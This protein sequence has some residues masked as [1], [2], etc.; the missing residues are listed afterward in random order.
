M[1]KIARLVAVDGIT[2]ENA[3]KVLADSLRGT[4]IVNAPTQLIQVIS[5]LNQQFANQISFSNKF[6][7][8]YATGYVGVHGDILYKN[9]SDIILSEIQVHYSNIYDGT[10]D[11][12]KE[13]THS[14]Y[15][16]TRSLVLSNTSESQELEVNGNAAQTIVF[17]FG[18]DRV[19]QGITPQPGASLTSS[20]TANSSYEYY[21]DSGVLFRSPPV[22]FN[23]SSNISADIPQLEVYSPI[24]S[25]WKIITNQSLLLDIYGD[26]MESDILSP[27]IARTILIN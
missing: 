15:E 11:C 4:I 19:I 16:T 26:L 22:V 13:Y 18:M 24:N 20:E 10:H 7:A 21:F 1:N 27:E 6:N 8:T 17:L 9:Q 14:I 2:E 12:P 23:T 25:A 3:P 5:L